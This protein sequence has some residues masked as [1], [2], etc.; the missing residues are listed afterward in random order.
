MPKVGHQVKAKKPRRT[1]KPQTL[2]AYIEAQYR[3]NPGLRR[4]VQAKLRKLEKEQD[5]AARRRNS[6]TNATPK[7][8]RA[9]IRRRTP[10]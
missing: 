8:S 2:E 6:P 10:Q 4:R 3:A 9:A 7:Q 1:K 5:A